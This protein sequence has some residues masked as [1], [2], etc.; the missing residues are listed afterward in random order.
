MPAAVAGAWLV[1][2]TLTPKFKGR[3]GLGP[4]EE[5]GVESQLNPAF[6]A[7]AVLAREAESAARAHVAQIP[8]AQIA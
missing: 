8:R 2:P 6:E 7:A 5:M 1:Y 4:R 3:V